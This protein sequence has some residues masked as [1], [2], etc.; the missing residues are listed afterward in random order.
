[1]IKAAMVFA[2]LAGLISAAPMLIAA[3]PVEDGYCIQYF[4]APETGRIYGMCNFVIFVLIPLII[5]VY[6]YGGMV[7]VMKRQMRVMAG[8]SSGDGSSQLNAS[9][10]QSK[11][12]KWNIIKTMI[13]VSVAFI[14]SWFPNS[15]YFIILTNS[16][17]GRDLAVG[18]YPTVF[19]IY[20]NVC[21]NPFIYATKHDGVKHQ[22]ARLMFW[23]RP[24]GVD[25]APGTSSNRTTRTHVAVTGQR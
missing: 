1:M 11:R 17:T 25:E 19:L 10:V 18:Y 13:I 24:T 23:R 2:W 3:K 12:V 9:Q 22:L 21:M 7:V 8:H 5:F 20:L 4:E 15:I 16:T 6:C 14:V